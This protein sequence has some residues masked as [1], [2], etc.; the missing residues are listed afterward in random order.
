[1][2]KTDE[3]GL[4]STRCDSSNVRVPVL[5]SMNTENYTV[6]CIHCSDDVR[7]AIGERKKMEQPETHSS[8]WPFA[9]G[10]VQP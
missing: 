4:G 7:S 10:P 8:I 6:L 2:K 3:R 5:R 9:Y 1:M